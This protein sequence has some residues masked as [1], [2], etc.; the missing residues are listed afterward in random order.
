MVVNNMYFTVNGFQ[1]YALKHNT[2]LRT[3]CRLHKNDHYFIH[4]LLVQQGRVGMGKTKQICANG[5]I[6]L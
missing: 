6:K 5:I 4:V 3:F 2:H 1:Q